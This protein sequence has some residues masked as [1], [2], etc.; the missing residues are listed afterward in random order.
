MA[1]DHTVPRTEHWG[2]P[3]PS[4]TSLTDNEGESKYKTET[5]KIGIKDIKH[6][7]GPLSPRGLYYDN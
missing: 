3:R 6:L 7:C 4:E 5:S 2:V 1:G